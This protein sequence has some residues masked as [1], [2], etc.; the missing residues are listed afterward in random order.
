[1]PEL[2]WE[3]SAFI[4]AIE[5]SPGDDAPKLVYA[6]WLEENGEEQVA[7]FVRGWVYVYR[8][9]VSRRHIT[10]LYR[11]RIQLQNEYYAVANRLNNNLRKVMIQNF[12][13]IRVSMPIKPSL[14]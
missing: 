9:F 13:E 12:D 2:S 14:H 8:L 3:E 11:S 6:D 5:H 1:M 7:S 10:E 4:E